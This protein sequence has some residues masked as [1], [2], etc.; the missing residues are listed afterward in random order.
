MPEP[1]PRWPYLHKGELDPRLQFPLL[2]SESDNLASRHSHGTLKTAGT[3]AKGGRSQQPGAGASG[4]LDGGGS[5]EGGL[6]NDD[7]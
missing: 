6:E 5:G 1:N 4:L 2:H 3:G 7:G